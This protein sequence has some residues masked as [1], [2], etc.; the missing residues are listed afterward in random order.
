MTPNNSADGLQ[1]PETVS[2]FPIYYGGGE[3]LKA[4]AGLKK[5]L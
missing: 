2:I 3:V 4:R 1:I 5:K